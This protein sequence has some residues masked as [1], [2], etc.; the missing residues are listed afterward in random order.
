MSASQQ[1]Q[2]GSQ[3]DN[4]LEVT[5]DRPFVKKC[6][7][8]EEANEPNIEGLKN[9]WPK[10]EGDKSTIGV[11]FT[12]PTLNGTHMTLGFLT[13]NDIVA[14]SNALAPIAEFIPGNTA[15]FNGYTFW[16]PNTAVFLKMERS[17]EDKCRNLDSKC[18]PEGNGRGRIYHVTFPL[19]PKK[20]DDGNNVLDDDGHIVWKK[21]FPDVSDE[22]F[23][24]CVAILN[25][26]NMKCFVGM[27]DDEILKE[28]SPHLF[29]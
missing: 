27:S 8:N 2:T 9:V 4:V 15:T 14:V 17:L 23:E 13:K 5:F 3:T 20:D 10:Q 1:S 12:N 11:G 24:R 22:K 6:G 28:V 25:H 18:T 21:R 19:V 26:P 16:G 29:E 7:R